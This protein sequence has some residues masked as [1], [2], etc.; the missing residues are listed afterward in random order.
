MLKNSAHFVEI[1]LHKPEQLAKLEP[2]RIKAWWA[3]R[4]WH[5]VVQMKW[6]SET[7]S[8]GEGLITYPD[9]TVQTYEMPEHGD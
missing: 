2:Y 3:N 6:V 8:N 9:G 7:K 1:Y 4:T 5:P